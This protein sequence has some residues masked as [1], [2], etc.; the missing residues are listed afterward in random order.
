[1]AVKD[2]GAEHISNMV[3][4]YP[5]YVNMPKFMSEEAATHAALDLIDAIQQPAPIAS[6]HPFGSA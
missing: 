3:N 1:M 5:S 2:T 6:F 4:F